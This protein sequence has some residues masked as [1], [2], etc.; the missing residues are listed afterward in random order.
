MLPDAA[1]PLAYPI[2]KVPVVTGFSRTRIFAAVR[3]KELTARKSG[4]ATIIETAEIARWLATLETR[5]RAPE[6]VT[7]A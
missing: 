2:E 1:Q 6:Q 5:G 3:N 4:R 7:A